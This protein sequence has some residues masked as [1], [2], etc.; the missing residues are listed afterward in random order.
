[1]GTRNDWRVTRLSDS[2]WLLR[3]PDFK[4]L[5]TAYSVG[6]KTNLVLG[7]VVGRQRGF[8]SLG[9]TI[10]DAV[11]FSVH[12][13]STVLE[14]MDTYCACVHPDSPVELVYH[15][16]GLLHNREIKMQAPYIGYMQ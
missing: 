16:G 9:S 15:W 6:Q 2:N 3:S 13:A 10:W 12:P 4:S 8:Y 11:I 7:E 1:M 5:L 14:V